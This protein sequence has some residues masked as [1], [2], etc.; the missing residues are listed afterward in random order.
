MKGLKYILIAIAFMISVNFAPSFA[1]GQNSY[2]LEKAMKY[3]RNI[4]QRHVP[5]YG[6]IV[7]S[8]YETGNLENLFI[9]MA[10]G[11]STMWTSTY[12][13]A[14]SFRYAVTGS[15]EAMENAIAAIQTLHDHKEVTG[16]VGYIGRYVGP[17]ETPFIFD[18][19][20]SPILRYGQ[21]QWA[22]TFWLGNSSSDQHIGY[23]FGMGIAYDLLDDEPT[24]ELV[25]SDLKEVFDR[26]RINNWL[27]RDENGLPTTAAPKISGS[28]R[29]AFCLIM[30]HIMDSEQYW[31]I[32]EKEFV[33]Q[34][35]AY[36]LNSIS[37]FNKYTEYFAYNLR[38]DNY[39]S[40]FKHEPDPDRRAFFWE[41]FNEQIR[42]HVAG[43]H[44]VWFDQVYL[45]A[46]DA[47]NDCSE[48]QKIIDDGIKSLTDFP[49]W[50]NRDIH[51]DCPALP[52][53]PISE[54]LVDLQELLGLE[55]ILGFELITKEPHEIKNRCRRGFLWQRSPNHVYCVGLLPQHIFPGVDYLLAYWAGRYYNFIDPVELD[56]DDFDD[57]DFDDDDTGDD[58]D[59]GD[60]DDVNENDDQSSS[61]GCGC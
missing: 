41:V 40:I 34:K 13:A 48:R 8:V 42:P 11:D 17:I 61:S 1:F 28:E 4:R 38:H 20:G 32:Y 9:Y 36:K 54:F 6:G 26:L 24:R 23:F 33:A 3:E 51:V 37:F 7:H 58:D 39:F 5:G 18:Y 16:T 49:S 19:L 55:D 45:L 43:T 27:I 50:P 14:E 52:I 21:G 46:C 60:D 10:Q 12:L 44:N 57:D 22:G 31:D 2:L 15:K 30:A 47:V 53:D 29:M 25:K 59:Q 56:D 35:G